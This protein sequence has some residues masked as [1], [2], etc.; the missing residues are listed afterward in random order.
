MTLADPGIGTVA[1]L[2]ARYER[3][4]LSPRAGPDVCLAC[5]NLTHGFDLCYACEHGGDELDAM[6]PISYSIAAEELHQALAGYKR[7]SGPLARGYAREL[8]A[9]LGRHMAVHEPCLAR[10]AGVERFELITTVPSSDRERDATSPLRRLVSE[11]CPGTC[12]RYLPLLKRSPRDAHAHEYSAAKFE[13]WLAL[14]LKGRSVLLI[15]DMWTTGANAH[16]AAGALKRAGAEIVAALVIGR[17][18][19]RGW[20]END[21]RLAQLSCPFDWARCALCG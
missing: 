12:A 18:V 15:D 17:H 7:L 19:N 1:S 8:A 9:V 13:P 11:L 21:A 16:S 5:F 3:F 2:T 14:P 10:A 4:L 20:R 6:L